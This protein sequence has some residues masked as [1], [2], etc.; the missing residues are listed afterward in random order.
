MVKMIELEDGNYIPEECCTF[1]NPLTSGGESYV[2]DVDLPCGAG[3]EN[4]CDKCIIQKVMNEYGKLTTQE[5]PRVYQNLQN[6]KKAW[7]DESFKDRKLA[8]THIKSLRSSIEQVEQLVKV[9]Q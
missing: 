7:E 2:D 8:E 1:T 5:I 4:D 6:M 9:V 3:C